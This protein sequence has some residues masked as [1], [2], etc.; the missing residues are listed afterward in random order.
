MP[1]L[2]PNPGFPAAIYRLGV[3]ACQA[4]ID[5]FP[6]PESLNLPK[7]RQTMAEWDRRAVAR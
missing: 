2:I 4:R 6:Y 3:E 7:L 5:H 1:S